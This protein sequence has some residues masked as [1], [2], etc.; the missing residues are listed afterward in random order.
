MP[1]TPDA[2]AYAMPTGTSIVVMT[3][4]A[5]RSCRSQ[6]ASYWR[7]VFS[8]GS[9]R[10]QPVSFTCAIAILCERPLRGRT[11]ATQARLF[12]VLAFWANLQSW[13]DPEAF[14]LY[15]ALSPCQPTGTRS[16]NVM[17]R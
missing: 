10:I 6:R 2:W 15:H 11:I 16:E 14:D 7:I 8:P 9:Q 3:R 4:P 5:T 1:G 17:Y 13:A 12:S